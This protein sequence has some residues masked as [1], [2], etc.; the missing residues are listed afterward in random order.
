MATTDHHPIIAINP[1]ALEYMEPI[2]EIFFRGMDLDGDYK[3]SKQEYSE[4]EK[5]MIS[6]IFLIWFG[7]K[8][9]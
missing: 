6:L 1:D 3:L 4:L 8:E 9:K 2:V 5:R 7:D